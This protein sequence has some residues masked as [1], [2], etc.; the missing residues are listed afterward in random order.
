M[1]LD[2]YLISYTKLGSKW[3]KDSIV[4]TKIIKFLEEN[5]GGKLLD[6]GL[7]KD[8]FEFNTNSNKSKSQQ[9]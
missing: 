9:V 1:K 7:G 8:F 3:I 6:I 4:T 2:H 5:T